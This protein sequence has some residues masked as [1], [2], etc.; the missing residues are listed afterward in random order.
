MVYLARG[1]A[2]QGLK[3]D[4]ILCQA[5]GTHLWKI[6]ADVRIINL[7]SNNHVATLKALVDYL[8]KERPAVLLSALHF[9]NELAILAKHWARV[10][11]R[12]VVCEQNTLSQRSRH[13]TR[14]SKRL[15]PWIAKLAYPR[16]DAVVAVSHGVAQDL[17]QVL[18]LP[19][20]EI[21]VIY[22]PG[23]TPE[24]A[25]KAQEPLEHPWFAA[26]EPPVILGVGKLE[27]QK[28]FPTLLQA[29]AQVRAQRPVRLVILGW[30][31]EAEQR[32]LEALIEELGIGADVQLAGYVN[33]PYAYMARS[34]L[35]VL[36]SR[37]EG[38][39]FVLVEA[40]AVGLPVVSTNCESGPAEILDHG[41][42]GTLVPV[43]DAQAMA[44]AIAQVLDGKTPPVKAGW[45]E[46][47]SLGAIVQQYLQVAQVTPG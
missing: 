4:F 19:L 18:G 21:D 5:T 31:P 15:T 41:Q 33:N 27:M 10:P 16:A 39:P 17:H 20:S 29:F 1:F 34:A 45:L 28:D 43:G 36:S 32:R 7:N 46:Q 3:V 2:E 26:G 37:W 44:R 35:F 25:S 6:P 22:N 12:V 13:E 42:Y 11:T 9:N 24:I 30:G 40:M 47:F 23:V 8:R 14:L 38:L